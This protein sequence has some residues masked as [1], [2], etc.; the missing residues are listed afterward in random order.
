VIGISRAEGAPSGDFHGERHIG[1]VEAK[2]GEGKA[3]GELGFPEAWEAEAGAGGAVSAAALAEFLPVGH[4]SFEDAGG[5]GGA[6]DAEGGEGERFV[7]HF[8]AVAER[9]MRKGTC[10]LEADHAGAHAAEW[11]GDAIQSRA[12]VGGVV[13]GGRGFG[14]G[15]VGMGDVSSGSVGGGCGGSAYA[16]GSHAGG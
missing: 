15:V 6:L 5:G 4:R 9:E 1:V 7:E 8:R 12:L 16:H 2:G 10:A 3:S 14:R 13:F 11:E